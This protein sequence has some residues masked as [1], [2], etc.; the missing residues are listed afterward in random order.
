[1]PKNT[2]FVQVFIGIARH[3][4]YRTFLSVQQESENV[5]T[6]NS[7]LTVVFMIIYY[8]FVIK[9]PKELKKNVKKS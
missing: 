9:R 1:M 3:Q 5:I 7:L 2:L 4:S 6:I 8:V